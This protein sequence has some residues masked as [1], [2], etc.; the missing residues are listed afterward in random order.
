VGEEE[1]FF[2]LKEL[3]REESQKRIR[4]DRRG[5]LTDKL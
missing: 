5:W 3:H 4:S 1:E 2:Y